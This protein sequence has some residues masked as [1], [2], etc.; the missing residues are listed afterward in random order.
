MDGDAEEP[1][2]VM[3]SSSSDAQPLA[4]LI[5]PPTY[6]KNGRVVFYILKDSITLEEQAF[7][8]DEAKIN[9]L[10][11]DHKDKLVPYCQRLLRLEGREEK[12]E[13]LMFATEG[14]PRLQWL[15]CAPE[16]LKVASD[17]LRRLYEQVE[18]VPLD[19][20]A[21][22]KRVWF[23]GTQR[24]TPFSA[25]TSS[26]FTEVITDPSYALGKAVNLFK[27]RIQPAADEEVLSFDDDQERSLLAQ[28]FG[29]YSDMR[30]SDFFQ[31]LAGMGEDFPFAGVVVEDESEYRRDYATAWF[32][33]PAKHLVIEEQVPNPDAFV[34]AFL[35]DLKRSED[36][37]EEAKEGDKSEDE[38]DEEDEDNEDNAED[39]D[40]GDD[41][42]DKKR[43]RKIALKDVN[44]RRLKTMRFK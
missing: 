24:P 14:V 28:C 16:A 30:F 10:L 19:R 11:A 41:E 40:K 7:F 23:C 25:T 44:P 18:H 21:K 12:T 38:E 36:E 9:R 39:K 2:C 15:P 27:L 31:F 22:D 3:L 34:A 1:I 4:A 32:K 37:E 35:A 42:G 8:R 29:S 43:G 6:S 17:Y 26:G 20:L 5:F 33:I 13:F